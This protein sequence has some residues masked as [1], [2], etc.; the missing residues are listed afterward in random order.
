MLGST[1][2]R[3]RLAS[4]MSQTELAH[5]AGV[6]ASFLSRVERDKREPTLSVLRRIAET[7]KTPFGILLAAAIG[8]V[9]DDPKWQSAMGKLIEAVRTQLLT[10]AVEQQSLFEAPDRERDPRR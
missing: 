9:T 6:T 4:G 3:L 2:R 1:I 5:G 10:D 7:L 8:D